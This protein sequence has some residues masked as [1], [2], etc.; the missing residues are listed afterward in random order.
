M[1]ELH[2]STLKRF[3]GIRKALGPVDL[4]PNFHSAG[5][6]ALL[7]EMLIGAGGLTDRRAVL[8]GGAARQSFDPKKH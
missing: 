8:S 5:T 1:A 7:V 6:G 2:A 4:Q 3:S